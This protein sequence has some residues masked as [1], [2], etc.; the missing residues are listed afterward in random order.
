MSASSRK[1]A[2]LSGHGHGH[3]HGKAPPVSERARRT[4]AAVLVP[5]ALATLGGVLVLYPFAAPP[6]GHADPGFGRVPVDGVILSAAAT[7]CGSGGSEH[8]E[9]A[10]T[11]CV[12]LRVRL[13]EGPATGTVITQTVPPGPGTPTFAVHDAV[14]LAYSGSA[15][16][17]AAS[18]Q[19]VDFQRGRWLLVLA[20]LFT[21][22]VLLLGRRQGL[23]SLA[24]LA[25]SFTVLAGFVFPAILAGRDPLAVAV[26]GSGVIM[27]TVL[28]LT[29]GPSAQTSTAVLGTLV[30][31][32]LIGG[33]SALFAWLT[34]ATGL[35]E[36][37]SMLIGALGTDIDARGL[38]LAGIVIGAL[39]VLDD[40]TVTQAS[41]VWELR[42]AS[43][44]LS[45][46]DLYAAGLRIGR[47]HVSSAVNTL[48]LAYAGAALPVLLLYS[49]SGHAFT[50]IVTSQAV[51]QEIL[52]TLVGSVGLV[53]AVPVTTAIAAA[54]A[55][56]DTGEQPRGSGH[57]YGAI[58][59]LV[60]QAALE[61]ATTAT[62]RQRGARHTHRL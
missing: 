8:D 12:R 26:V 32:S 51:A 1:D 5:F 43:P 62:L 10:G 42:R 27:F 14:V 19:I 22:A 50:D 24:A 7:S 61:G 23:M 55:L 13:Q 49:L 41:A 29:H 48:V 18:Y 45:W 35:G 56:S 4:L 30:S 39:G 20:G 3:G 47:D 28:Y 46:R 6:A 53:A 9:G 54:V 21:V 2:P 15:P 36:D 44:G 60:R 33:L 25:L 16:D 52:R 58:A 34:H 57:S 38:L 11:G 37:T 31:L 17:R 40:V 59:A